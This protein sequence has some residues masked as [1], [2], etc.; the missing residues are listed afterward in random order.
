VSH[1]GL[2]PHADDL[3]PSAGPPH[4]RPRSEPEVIHTGVVGDRDR[5]T[6]PSERLDREVRVEWTG[7]QHASKIPP[8]EPLADEIGLV[9]VLV[10]IEDLGESAVRESAGQPYRSEHLR[11]LNRVAIEDLDGD[12]APK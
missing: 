3:D 10:G 4:D 2:D 11:H 7:G 1:G 6:S 9:S 5:F 8:A 12:R